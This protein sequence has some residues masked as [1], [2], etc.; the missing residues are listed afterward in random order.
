V[1]RDPETGEYTIEDLQSTNGSK[2]NGKR[3]RNATLVDG[4]EIE[5]GKTKFKFILNSS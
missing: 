2:V 1:S 5:V 4:D 3:V